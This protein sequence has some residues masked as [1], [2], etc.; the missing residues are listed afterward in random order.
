MVIRLH[1]GFVNVLMV[2]LT[3]IITQVILEK[4]LRSERVVKRWRDTEILIIDE[5][6]M[7]SLRTSEIIHFIA[8]GVRKSKQAFGGC[9]NS[10]V[11]GLQTVT[12]CLQ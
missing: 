11:R 5:V 10:C 12:T 2:I 3:F 6:S 9:T 8:Q 4:V 7:L 1:R